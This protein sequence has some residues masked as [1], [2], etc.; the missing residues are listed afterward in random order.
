MFVAVGF[1]EIPKPN[2]G[3]I[4]IRRIVFCDTFCFLKPE[5]FAQSQ[6]IQCFLLAMGT[7]RKTQLSEHAHS[8]GETRGRESS[9]PKF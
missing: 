5:F 1:K 7:K 3:I 8:S 6:T 4:N 2:I 9:T